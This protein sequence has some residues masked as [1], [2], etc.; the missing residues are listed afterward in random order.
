MHEGH[1]ERVKAKFLQN[2]LDNFESHNI[3][4]LLL[5]NVIPRKDT[6]IIAHKLLD[7]FG[8]L[9]GVFDAP[10]EELLKV[11][12]IGSSAATLIKLIPQLC[13]H[14]LDDKQHDKNRIYNT[15]SAGKMLLHKYIGRTNEVVVL[16]LLD[17]KGRQIYCGVVNE[18]SVNTVPIYVRRIMELA[19]RYNAAAAILS[20]N[21]PSGNTM[22]SA[23]DI[24]STKEV[25]KALAVVH[26]RLNDHI[27]V[28]DGDYFS[29]ADSGLMKNIFEQEAE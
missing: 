8:S 26:V 9:S 10:Y 25:Y 6:N 29:M 1:R 13:R 21:H 19:V 4:E 15:E 7:T 3:L 24:S 16:L 11:E 28:V 5:Y 17:S 14:Y 23:G 2:G 22:P 12:G 20:H 18:G 27:I